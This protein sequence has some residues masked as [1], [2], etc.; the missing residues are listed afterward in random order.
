M[1]LF[2]KVCDILSEKSEAILMTIDGEIQEPNGSPAW[3]NVGQALNM[4]FRFPEDR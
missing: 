2:L 3:G 1:K 4:D